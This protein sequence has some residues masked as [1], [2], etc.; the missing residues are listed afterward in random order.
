MASILLHSPLIWVGL[1]AVVVWRIHARIRALVGRQRLP[2]VRPW[3]MAIGL[4]LAFLLAFGIAV[5]HPPALLALLG[6]GAIGALLGRYG[7]ALTTFDITP[8]G[9]FYTPNPYLGMALALLLIGRIA[10]RLFALASDPLPIATDSPTPLTMFFLGIVAGY[11]VVYESGLIRWGR[12]SATL[13]A[14]AQ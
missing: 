4:A 3:V 5:A 14:T 6:G 2:R 8:D 1:G 7:L 12:R 13:T 10:V 11:Y 9:R